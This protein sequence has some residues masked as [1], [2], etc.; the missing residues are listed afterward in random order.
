MLLLHGRPGAAAAELTWGDSRALPAY[1]A[2]QSRI[3]VSLGIAACILVASRRL[4]RAGRS[5]HRQVR[6]N[7]EPQWDVE[8]DGI[9]GDDDVLEGGAPLNELQS[10][11]SNLRSGE[12]SGAG[13][14]EQTDE[15]ADLEDTGVDVSKIERS[16]RVAVLGVPNAG[17]SSLV[18]EL[19]GTKVSIVTHK[20]QTT[21]QRVMGLA[22][23]APRVGME[24]NTQA[25]FMDTAGIMVLGDIPGEVP[26]NMRARA[27]KLFKENR[28]HKA[29]VRTAWKAI[30]E[31]D[32]VF[33]V[34]DA[35][36]C[37][38]YGDYLPEAPLLDGIPV[39]PSVP[40]AWWCH[41]EMSEELGFIRRIRKIK[42]PV[43][44]VLNKVDLLE[45][46]DVDVEAF[47]YLMRKVLKRDLGNDENGN[48][49]FQNVW[50]TSVTKNPVSLAPLRVWLC[51][52]MPRRGLLYP[53]EA[54][55]DVPARVAASEI[56]REKLFEVLDHQVPYQTCVV[57]LVWR[58]EEDGT[59]K[60]GQR[61]VVKGPYEA[62][63]VRT[64]LRRVAEAA[65]EEI[66][67]IVNFGRPVELH[68]QVKV[69]PK[70]EDNSEY[71]ADL[72][73][74]L[75]QGTLLFPEKKR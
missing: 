13:M 60:L 67:D 71:Y 24:P 39:G 74:L 72:N 25:I 52:N 59:L 20:P 30:R 65:E 18:N 58:E 44:V 27:R 11:L 14:V 35:W 40:D 6:R 51:E 29:M 46:H 10:M 7:A 33:W 28:L 45:D 47:T 12:S 63:V 66:S 73:G 41:P 4:R 42:Q 53:A 54:V 16:G 64:C 43:H 48:P 3:G 1:R 21:R 22:L 56:V 69:E 70:W 15:A 36:K 62:R 49:L 57:N 8:I 68:F 37:S 23:L 9:D 32:A 31:A 34:L 19:V 5:R 50:P 26:G 55:S 75:E 38:Q 2:E 17:K 61:V